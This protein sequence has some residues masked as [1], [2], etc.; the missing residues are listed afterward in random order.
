V[1]QSSCPGVSVETTVALPQNVLSVRR[2]Q[3]RLLACLAVVCAS[4]WLG[5]LRIASQM[6]GGSPHPHHGALWPL[7]FMWGAMMVAMMVPP[8]VPR[9]LWLARAH[10]QARHDPLLHALAFLGG[11][12]APWMVASLLAA[13]LQ[14]KLGAAGLMTEEM[15]TGSRTLGGAL[16]LV[17]GAM[18]LSPLK[19][20]CL[21]R[22]RSRA[23]LAAT[24]GETSGESF[25]RGTGHGAMSIGSCGLLMLV[26]FVTG[27][28]SALAM[29]LLTT[30]LLLE[31]VAPAR[32]PVRW[33]A[34]V[35]LLCW[36]ASLFLV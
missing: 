6:G 22:C 31:N 29:A 10:G 32:W 4:A 5:S 21:E 11:Y 20:A 30:L 8:E 28:M 1:W 35:L 36:G 12:L 15:A 2:D 13:L 23:A 17:A 14:A 7:A 3:R 9:L 27:V 33:V 34:G 25:L 16:L 19:R 18:Q 26:L 24:P